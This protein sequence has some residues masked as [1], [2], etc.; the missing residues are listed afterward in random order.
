MKQTRNEKGFSMIELIVVVAIMAIIGAVLIPQFSTMST[1]AR[2]TT[3]ASS[4]KAVQQQVDVYM[5]DLGT[6]PGGTISADDDVNANVISELLDKKYLDTKYLSGGQL[7]LQTTPA[8]CKYDD[9]KGHFVL[10]VD[11]DAYSALRDND[12]NKDEW[13]QAEGTLSIN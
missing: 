5:V 13:I 8:A 10:V 7:L 3:D 11:S 6:T 4:V 2:L 9:A 1:R 12:A